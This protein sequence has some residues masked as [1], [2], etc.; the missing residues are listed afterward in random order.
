MKKESGVHLKAFLLLL[1]EILIAII[2]FLVLWQVGVA[3][4]FWAY[5]AVGVACGV[6]YWVLYR[7]VLDQ[8]RKSPVDCD[9][10]VGIRGRCV[11]SL[12]PE[13]LVRVRGETWKAVT[14]CGV[15]AEGAEV[16]VEDLESLTL[17]VTA[18]KSTNRD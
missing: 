18:S 8:R 14:R 6:L 3:I 11:N 15:I 17:V 13:G 9:S 12:N 1:D 10:L 5:I 4:P 7:I 16:V 2:V